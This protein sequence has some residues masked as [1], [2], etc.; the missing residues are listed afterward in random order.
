MNDAFAA[1]KDVRSA[2]DAVS[3]NPG[4]VMAQAAFA[5]AHQAHANTYVEAFDI[6]G[7][8]YPR[9]DGHKLSERE[10]RAAISKLLASGHSARDFRPSVIRA[11]YPL[12]EEVLHQEVEEMVCLAKEIVALDWLTAVIDP[13]IKTKVRALLR[14]PTECGS[15]DDMQK[16][17][18]A[19]NERRNQALLNHEPFDEPLRGYDADHLI[20][21]QVL[22]GSCLR[23]ASVTKAGSYATWLQDSQ[24]AGSQH[25]F[26][27]DAQNDAKK[28]I[29]DD[30]GNRNNPK[31]SQYLQYAFEWMTD[32][33]TVDH[34]AV[35]IAI[36]DT[37]LRNGDHYN[38]FSVKGFALA[39]A[40][41]MTWHERQ[42]IGKAVA[43]VLL[44]DA[45][46]F[47]T[48]IGWGM[49]EELPL[50]NDIKP[51]VAQQPIPNTSSQP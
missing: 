8:T 16:A 23:N 38:E 6:G 34:L 18:K 42:L 12:A 22:R 40:G 5:A 4:D 21:D 32:L 11:A 48:S 51:T 26:A 29:E 10:A 33:Y 35:D 3:Q 7:V 44:I 41:F 17:K 27:T 30:Q 50:F 9:T 24:N 1:M 15:Y 14:M 43:T 39:Q 13:A 49:D 20:P 31:V 47:Y 37:R 46:E 25:K 19:A 28:R 45:R 36:H 2:Y